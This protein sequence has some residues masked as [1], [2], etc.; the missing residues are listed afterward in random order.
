MTGFVYGVFSACQCRLSAEQAKQAAN[1]GQPGHAGCSAQSTAKRIAACGRGA[2]A[3]RSI[4]AV[5]QI[6][7]VLQGQHL[8]VGIVGMPPELDARRE[9]RRE[10]LI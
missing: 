5:D 10:K 3:A 7:I 6:H 4:L 1:S 8:P 9:I 2:G